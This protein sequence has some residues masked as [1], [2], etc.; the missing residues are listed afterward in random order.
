[1]EQCPGWVYDE[2]SSCSTTCGSGIKTRTVLC[3]HDNGTVLSDIKCNQIG[4]P[5]DRIACNEV[6][7]PKW[8][9]ESWKKC[10]PFECKQRRHVYCASAIGLPLDAKSCD[11][12]DK[13][14]DVKPCD[15]TKD[16][17]LVFK[18]TSDKNERNLSSAWFVDK[19]PWDKCSVSCGSGGTQTRLVTCRLKDKNTTQVGL[20]LCNLTS[21]RETR[22]CSSNIVC[23]YKLNE[24]WS[25]C[26]GVCGQVGSTQSMHV[27][28]DVKTRKK[29]NVEL[30]GISNGQQLKT[31]NATCTPSNSTCLR[32]KQFEWKV[33][34]WD[35][36]SLN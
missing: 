32:T 3:K 8:R 26:E 19:T 16:C 25:V 31:R 11:S 24:E 30:C 34:N 21:G 28:R 6:P 5:G 10:D 20:K 22:T 29:V 36:V 27:C 33:G 18:Q 15:V 4:R 7:C 1:M 9:I 12:M 35:R 23:P 2:W 13:P 14:V 17:I